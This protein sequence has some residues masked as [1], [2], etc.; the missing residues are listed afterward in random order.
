LLAYIELR[1]NDSFQ[2]KL[3]CN[4]ELSVKS[5]G[6]LRHVVEQKKTQVPH[7]L[8]DAFMADFED[9]FTETNLEVS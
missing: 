4:L 6:D 8:P 3:F 2:D 9:F 5:Y 7:K 1:T